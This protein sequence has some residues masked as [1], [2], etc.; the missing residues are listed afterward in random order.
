MADTKAK[1]EKRT[2]APSAARL[3]LIE[4]QVLA[5]RLALAA[6]LPDTAQLIETLLHTPRTKWP[7]ALAAVRARRKRA[8]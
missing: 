3:D 2:E 5:V 6:T 8:K 4:T 7:M 1:T